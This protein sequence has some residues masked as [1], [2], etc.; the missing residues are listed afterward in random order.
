M[1]IGQTSSLAGGGGVIGGTPVQ[2]TFWLQAST[3]SQSL[4]STEQYLPSPD[5]LGA[6]QNLDRFR[7][8][9]TS[10]RQ[11]WEQSVH[12]PQGPQLPSNPFGKNVSSS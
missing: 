7:V 3:W 6:L 8:P 10:S 1:R 11:V 12:G 2:G 5:G 9:T 4:P